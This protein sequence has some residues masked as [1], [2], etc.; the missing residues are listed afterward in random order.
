[1]EVRAREL[2]HSELRL[3]DRGNWVLFLAHQPPERLVVFVHGFRGGPVASWRQFQLGGQRS[4]WW[5]ATDLLFVGYASERDTILGVSNRLR[6]A[7][8]D[9]YPYLPD[10]LVEPSR[11]PAVRPTHGKYEELV[12][13]GHS[14][15]GVV[16]R[17]LLCDAAEEW[18]GELETDPST[19]RPPILDASLALF[20]PASAGF[21]PGGSL[22]MLRA[23]PLWTYI[24]VYLRRST[25]YSDL[26]PSSVF[27][28][29]TRRRTEAA[30]AGNRSAELKGLRANILWANPDD[31]VLTERY[32][33]DRPDR[34]AD[35][36]TH[37]SVCK[38]DAAYD[39]PW[40]FVEGA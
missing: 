24:N 14:L 17:R 38:P 11:G 15:G 16:V 33:S 6:Q 4:N 32:S 5:R 35:N 20:S 28:R 27:L 22:G 3:L 29:E 40:D 2:T 36:T 30:L 34:S 7:L 10:E 26:Q 31:V 1:M 12:L 39:L 19:P 23:L 21:R 18:L 37:R 25:A 8:P 13:V 9:F